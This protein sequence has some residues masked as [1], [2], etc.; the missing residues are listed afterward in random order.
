MQEACEA[1]RQSSL[2]GT[3]YPRS[4]WGE[5]WKKGPELLSQERS[6]QYA[7]SRSCHLGSQVPG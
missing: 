2:E 5:G 7:T 6:A 1:S 3:S 4:P